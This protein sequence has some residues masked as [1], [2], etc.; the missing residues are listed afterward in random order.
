MAAAVPRVLFVL[1]GGAIRDCLPTHFVA[2]IAAVI[3]T[4]LIGLVAAML[5]SNAFYLNVLIL[6]AALFGLSEA[7]L[8]PAILALLPQ[9]VSKSRLAQANAWMQGSE[10]ITN[11]IGLAAAG[12]VIGA[13]RLP[14]CLRSVAG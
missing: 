9:L 11:V 2:A 1:I 4:T 10:Q 14:H 6:I 3:N 7:F 13:L 12:L 5:F 8:Y